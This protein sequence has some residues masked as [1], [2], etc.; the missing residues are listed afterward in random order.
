MFAVCT[1]SQSKDVL[2]RIVRVQRVILEPL[3]LHRLIK[4]YFNRIVA[5]AERES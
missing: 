3:G 2:E 4:C 5:S 1:E